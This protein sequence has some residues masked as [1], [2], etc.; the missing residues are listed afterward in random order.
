[1]G[2]AV[3]F[4]VILAFAIL[5]A[6]IL[7]G[8]KDSPL[9]RIQWVLLAIGLTQVP[10][11]AGLFVVVWLFAIAWRQRLDPTQI[12]I[13]WFNLRQ[14]FLILMTAIAL[15]ILVAAVGK[16]LLGEPEMYINGNGSYRTHLK[17]YQP[18]V[19][20]DLPQPVIVTVSVWYYR[21]LM[22]LWSLWLAFAVLGWLSK[23]W[24]AF[25]SGGVWRHRA[26]LVKTESLPTT[27]EA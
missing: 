23:G 4:W 27:N 7:G 13:W 21:L 19:G 10:V 16:G 9:G 22:L 12:R 14:I 8:I 17:W 2:P 25:V 5:A 3:R 11:I 24:K 1:M 18:R 6:L 26:K 15:G 20:V